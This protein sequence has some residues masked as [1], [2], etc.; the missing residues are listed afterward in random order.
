MGYYISYFS[1][2][3]ELASH[4]DL[5]SLLAIL[6]KYD[7]Q[8]ILINIYAIIIQTDKSN[9]MLLLQDIRSSFK[10]EINTDNYQKYQEILVDHN[11]L[12]FT[13]Q[14]KITNGKINHIK[15]EKIS[16]L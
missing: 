9:K 10:L 15:L 6:Q 3:K 7:N 14:I 2:W 11:E 13:C 4:Y 8:E 12:L 16:E 5:T 1:R